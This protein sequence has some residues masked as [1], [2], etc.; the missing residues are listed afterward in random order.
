MDW[1]QYAL[2]DW[3]IYHDA[4]RIKKYVEFGKINSTQFQE[5]TGEVY[6]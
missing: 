5:I 1:Y 4:A 6:A 2:N 3:G